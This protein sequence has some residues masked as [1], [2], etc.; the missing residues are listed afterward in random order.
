MVQLDREITSFLTDADTRTL[1]EILAR[2]SRL[3]LSWT[4]V[5]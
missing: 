2:S 3:A 1:D 4:S 5:R